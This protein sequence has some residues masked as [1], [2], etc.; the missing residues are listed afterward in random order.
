MRALRIR[1]RPEWTMGLVLLG[2]WPLLASCGESQTT[3]GGGGQVAVAP[4]ESMMDVETTEDPMVVQAQAEVIVSELKDLKV[5]TSSSESFISKTL[6]QPTLE[7]QAKAV[8]VIEAA[9]GVDP[10]YKPTARQLLDKQLELA[11]PEDKFYWET[12]INR[13]F[14]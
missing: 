5:V 6:A 11:L 14:K 7:L 8:P 12:E 4:A 3:S 10:K 9:I 2:A 13:I 1:L